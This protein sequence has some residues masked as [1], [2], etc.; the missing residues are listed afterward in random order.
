MLK[1]KNIPNLTNFNIKKVI[2]QLKFH[3]VHFQNRSYGFFNFMNDISAESFFIAFVH[4]VK[5]PL[6]LKEK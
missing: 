6:I 5:I 3:R 4:K 2:S 1:L